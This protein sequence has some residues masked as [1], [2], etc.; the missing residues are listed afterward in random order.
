V[1]LCGG[2]RRAATHKIEV[3]TQFRLAPAHIN[4]PVD[5]HVPGGEHPRTAFPNMS[6]IAARDRTRCGGVVSKGS[7]EER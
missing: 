2:H 7:G 6:A 4:I 1:N 5:G 3:G